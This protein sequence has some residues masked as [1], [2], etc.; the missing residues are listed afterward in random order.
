V[1]VPTL[2]VPN[3]PVEFERHGNADIPELKSVPEWLE[4]ELAKTA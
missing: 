3:D 2:Q 4:E 1:G